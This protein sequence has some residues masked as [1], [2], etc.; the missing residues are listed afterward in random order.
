MIQSAIFRISIKLTRVRKPYVQTKE[1]C[2]SDF[3]ALA[4]Q[5]LLTPMIL[6]FALG[7]FAAL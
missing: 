5:N 3:L 6:C 1:L 2:M 7:V 4:Q